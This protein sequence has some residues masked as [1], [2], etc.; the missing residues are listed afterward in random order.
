MLRGLPSIIIVC[1]KLS[2]R[3][4]R[5]EK[6]TITNRIKFKQ[7]IFMEAKLKKSSQKKKKIVKQTDNTVLKLLLNENEANIYMIVRNIR[8][9]P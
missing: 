1:H 2:E 4:A 6:K 3:W 7:N 8:G 5:L 9:H